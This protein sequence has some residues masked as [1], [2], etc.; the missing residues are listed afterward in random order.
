MRYL[1]IILLFA[2]CVSEKKAMNR[3][4]GKVLTSQD[5]TSKVI[6]SYLK[7]NPPKNDTTFIPGKEVV[8]TR[9]ERDT[10][11]LP[12]PVK[13]KYIERHY[14]ESN[15]VDTARIKDRELLK[16]VV[17]RLDSIEVQ[18]KVMTKE[19]DYWKKEAQNRLYILI[20][21]AALVFGAILFRVL[22]G[23][24]LI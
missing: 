21:I 16:A 2:S 1:L 3:A 6:S 4:V 5:A 12:Y 17:A 14:T 9:V 23:F 11:P 15:R 22:K 7:A 13:E 20:G 24:K 18:L 10:I 19:R 8:T